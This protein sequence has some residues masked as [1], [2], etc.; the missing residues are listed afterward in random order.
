MMYISK[1]IT[2]FENLYDET[3][4][5]NK[6]TLGVNVSSSDGKL[7][8]LNSLTSIPSSISSVNNTW[9]SD[10][11]VKHPNGIYYSVF[12]NPIGVKNNTLTYQGN[13]GLYH[14]NDFFRSY[15]IVDNVYYSYGNVST[16][17]SLLVLNNSSVI[18]FILS[19]ACG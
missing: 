7:Y 8:R 15:D 2:A 11:I 12:V 19:I 4:M 13:S 18:Q 9:N 17:D 5:L 3:I 10:N 6:D 14:S 16:S 1:G